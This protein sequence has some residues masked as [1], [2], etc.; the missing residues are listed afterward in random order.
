MEVES[1]R[2]HGWDLVA[3]AYFKYMYETTA[4]TYYSVNRLE[5]IVCA[6]SAAE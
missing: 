4:G 1:G 5:C 6:G 2:L 3:G